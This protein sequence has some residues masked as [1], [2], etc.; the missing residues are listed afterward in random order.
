[1]AFICSVDCIKDTVWGI[2]ECFNWG[3]KWI[4]RRITPSGPSWVPLHI[5][6]THYHAKAHTDML[7]CMDH[8]G[9][10]VHS[11]TGGIQA[12]INMLMYA[13]IKKLEMRANHKH[14]RCIFENCS[15]MCEYLSVPS[16]SCQTWCW[17]NMTKSQHA[18][19]HTVTILTCW[20]EGDN[21]WGEHVQHV[22]RLNSVCSLANICPGG[23]NLSCDARQP[24][25]Q[26]PWAVILGWGERS[27][28]FNGHQEITTV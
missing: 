7:Y 5:P 1:M 22:S 8:R 27:I 24:L 10:C 3:N 12:L 6:Y 9:I 11:C 15:C 26:R 21:D 25:S 2:V 18:N 16:C 28:T 4:K 14:S 17:L 19:M 13:V 23:I 20:W